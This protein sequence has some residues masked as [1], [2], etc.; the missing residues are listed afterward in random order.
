M[1]LLGIDAGRVLW[2]GRPITDADRRRTGY[3]PEERGLYPKQKI[4]DQ[5]TYLGE[6]SGM[7]AST[8][9]AAIMEHLERFGLADRADDRVEKLSLGNQQRVQIIAALMTQ[10]DALILDEPFS[11]LDPTAVDS[12]A[13]LL[14]EHTA[15]GIPVLF[16]SHQLDLVE[17]LCDHLVVLAKG[18]VVADGTVDQLR[19]RGP[20][21]YRLVLGSDAGWVRDVP[22]IHA[23][24]VD[25]G[26]A[27][28]ELTG[29]V[30]DAD[31]TLLRDALSRGEV[32]EFARVIAPLSEIYRE[33]TA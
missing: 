17:R 20:E 5:L 15:R 11:G 30:P 3:M 21:R 32:K 9:R 25:G 6:L 1:G 2:N 13:D 33:V 31:Q 14:R 12:M 24:D 7:S 28:I 23:V 10:P 18:R 29:E 16:S 4:V 19:N 26:R 27:V 22:G 8:A